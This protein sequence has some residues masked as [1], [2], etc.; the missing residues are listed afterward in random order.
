MTDIEIKMISI[1]IVIFVKLNFLGVF[2]KYLTAEK[3]A[4]KASP[5]INNK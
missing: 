3:I 1:K 5:I 4:I 2:L